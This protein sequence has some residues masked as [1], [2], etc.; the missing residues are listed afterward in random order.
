MDSRLHVGFTCC[1]GDC[2]WPP[3]CLR[4]RVPVQHRFRA[5][6]PSPSALISHC[7]CISSPSPS[8][9]ISHLHDMASASLSTKA[10]VLLLGEVSRADPVTSQ[11]NVCLSFSKTALSGVRL[12]SGNLDCQQLSVRHSSG[13]R[14]SG[15][16][17]RAGL[18]D[19][20]TRGKEEQRTELKESLLES[21]KSL[22]RG[23]NAD[24]EDQAAVEAVGVPF[25]IGDVMIFLANDC[26]LL[27]QILFQIRIY[28]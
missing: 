9:L 28:V 11:S 18:F 20:F 26:R 27:L 10:N 4:S 3:L 19:F 8:A 13:K 21:V 15:Q 12:S 24:E 22:S 25:I 6:P 23:A 14:A 17:V 7:F 16:V 1:G 5:S 2:A